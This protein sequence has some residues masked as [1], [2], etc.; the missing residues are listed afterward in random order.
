LF[1][2]CQ[3]Q[4]ICFQV[5]L[6]CIRNSY[7]LFSLLFFNFLFRFRTI[8]LNSFI[9]RPQIIHPSIMRFSSHQD[10]I[11]NAIWKLITLVFLRSWCPRSYEIAYEFILQIALWNCLGRLFFI[12]LILQF[13]LFQF[14][15]YFCL[16]CWFAN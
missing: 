16:F 2:I 6:C 3:F 4:F 5:I 8:F 11:T 9:F 13:W 12:L 14:W 1:I 7:K 15:K 10:R